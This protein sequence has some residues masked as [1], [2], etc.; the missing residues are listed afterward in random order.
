MP[1]L[2]PTNHFAEVV[3]LGRV[4]SRPVALESANLDSIDLKF[5]GALGEDH[6]GLTRPACSRVSAQYPRGTIIRNVRQLSVVS[7]EELKAIAQGMGVERLEPEWVGASLV[8]SGIE[9]FSHIPPSS[10]L[11]ADSGATL[12]VDMQN[13]PC[14]FPGEVIEKAHPGKGPLFKSA[15]KGKRGITAWVEAEGRIK[16]GDLLRLHIPDQRAWAGEG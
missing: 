11:Q 12:V 8:L 7:A 1:A 15:A 10:R 5:S 14:R 16:L 6:S 2:I 4:A 9:D 13:R 3:W